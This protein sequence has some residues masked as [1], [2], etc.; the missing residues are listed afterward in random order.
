MIVDLL[1]SL[2]IK[3]YFLNMHGINPIDPGRNIDWGN[4]SDDYSVFRPGPP[5]SFYKRLEALG[6]GCPNQKILDVGTGTGVLA[7]RF[8]EQGSIVCGSDVSEEQIQA[9]KK[10][11]NEQ[12]LNIDFRVEPAE[13]SSF[14]SNSF[15]VITANQCFL[16]FDKQKI[17]PEIKRLLANGGLLVT[18][19][20]SWLPRL[21]KVAKA[22]EKLILK[23]N[24]NWTAKDWPGII[25]ASPIW[26]QDDFNLKAMFYYDEAISFT[27]ETWR[28]RIRACRGVGAALSSVEVENFDRAH[29][30]LLKKIT[31]DEFTVLHR[32]DAHFFELK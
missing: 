17:I 16:Y 1:A 8:A 7:R 24:P 20:F 25:P 31:A 3:S 30:D 10:L 15:D 13:K 12:K 11:A 14:A 2:N 5:D 28:G 6:V 4:T 27:R 32:I 22:S 23:F 9:A 26:A 18:S 21:D 29:D 19:H